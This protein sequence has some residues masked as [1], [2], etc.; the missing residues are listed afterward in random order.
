MQPN[1]DFLVTTGC[2]TVSIHRWD[3]QSQSWSN[4]WSWSGHPFVGAGST[5]LSTGGALFVTNSFPAQLF[6]WDPSAGFTWLGMSATPRTVGNSLH[7][8]GGDVRAILVDASGNL[9]A[10]SLSPSGATVGYPPPW[11]LTG[12]PLATQRGT[13]GKAYAAA[14]DSWSVYVVDDLCGT[15]AWLT[16][17]QP[18][19]KPLAMAWS[20]GALMNDPW[21]T[22]GKFFVTGADPVSGLIELYQ[23]YEA[24]PG[25]WVWHN[26]GLPP[27]CTE[28][29]GD[30]VAM[31]DGSLVVLGRDTAGL[32]GVARLDYDASAGWVWTYLG[33]PS[34]TIELRGN[35]PYDGSLIAAYGAQRAV[36]KSTTGNFWMLEMG[37]CGG[38]WQFL[39]TPCN[40]PASIGPVQRCFTPDRFGNLPPDRMQVVAAYDGNGTAATL[41]IH[42]W[43]PVTRNCAVLHVDGLNANDILTEEYQMHGYEPTGVVEVNGVSPNGVID[44]VAFGLYFRN[45]AGDRS[46]LRSAAPGLAAGTPNFAGGWPVAWGQTLWDSKMTALTGTTYDDFVARRQAQITLAGAQFLPNGVHGIPTDALVGDIDLNGVI[47]FADQILLQQNAGAGCGPDVSPCIGAPVPFTSDRFSA[48]PADRMQVIAFYDGDGSAATLAIQLRHPV[49]DERCVLTVNNLSN[50]TI[51]TNEYVMNGFEPTGLFEISGVVTNGSV[52]GVAFGLYW[53]NA[54]GDRRML[55]SSEPGNGGTPNFVGGWPLALSEADWDARMPQLAGGGV[56]GS[57]ARRQAQC[58]LSGAQLLGNG[59][60]VAYTGFWG[61]IDGDLN[62]DAC[63]DTLDDAILSANMAQGCP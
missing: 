1:G 8:C 58:T 34:E 20:L 11:P 16:P 7:D 63:V 59:T 23:F 30:P 56:T 19:D 28:V 37:A 14:T 12:A 43:H 50:T 44:G 60:H 6:R 15:P 26:H 32:P 40:P 25:T 13:S 3:Y 62:G 5:P 46:V 21:S 38:F 61:R 54:A 48:L 45:T 42:L 33:A 24:S 29:I 31:G 35:W 17:R 18:G 39:G 53:R 10:R 51:L 41:D 4:D 47:D 49:T 27:G 36:V 52:D 9:V 57:V 22:L 55:R 2:P